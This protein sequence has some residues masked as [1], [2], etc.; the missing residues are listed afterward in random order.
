MVFGLIGLIFN[1]VTFPGMLINGLVQDRFDGTYGVPE[2][3]VAFD[4]DLDVDDADLDEEALADVARVLDDG[5]SAGEGETAE[6]IVNYEGV[7][8]FPDLFKVVIYPFVLTSLLAGA[9]FAV[10]GGL[11]EFGLLSQDGNLWL[12][13]FWIGFATAA[14]AF[15]NQDPTDALWRRSSQTSSPLKFLGYPVVGVS[16]L[17]NALEFLWLDAVYALV[18]WAAIGTVMGL[19]L[20]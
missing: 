6:W 1:V 9:V 15:P 4:D 5:E 17:I 3:R 10:T 18:L 11:I 16:K 20:I 13:P 14:H 2:A 19:S 8:R 7:E 12:I